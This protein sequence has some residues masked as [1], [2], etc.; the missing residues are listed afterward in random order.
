M[1]PIVIDPQIRGRFEVTFPDGRR[2]QMVTL[3]QW[4]TYEGLLEGHP[5]PRVNEIIIRRAK[6]SAERHFETDKPITL[7]PPEVSPYNFPTLDTGTFVRCEVF[8][9]ITCC[10]C[11][12]SNPTSKGEGE[13]RSSAVV[14][15]FQHEWGPPNFDLCKQ[16]TAL[17]W[18]EIAS[19]WSY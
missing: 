13:C 12:D 18:D 10:A 16:I 19:D 5:G 3:V 14:I 9:A 17:K 1:K 7:I 2:A 15:W 11:F 4:Q 8:P 6:D